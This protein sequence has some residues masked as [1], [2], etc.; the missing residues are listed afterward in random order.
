MVS[1]KNEFLMKDWESCTCPREVTGPVCRGSGPG[2]FLASPNPRQS[3]GPS[4]APTLLPKKAFSYI[5][6]NL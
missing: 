3:Q 1:V 5:I 2:P 6:S 4:Q